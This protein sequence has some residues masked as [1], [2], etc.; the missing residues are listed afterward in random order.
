[1]DFETIFET[2]NLIFRKITEDDFFNLSPILKNPEI[3][4]AWEHGFSDKEVYN[5]IEENIRRYMEDKISYCIG[6]EKKTG[7][8]IGMIG[9]LM[10][11]I[12][13]EKFVG[14]GWI[15]DKNFWG[16]GYAVEGGRGAINYAF[17][18]MNND[19]VVATIRTENISSRKVAEKLGM[20]IEGSYIKKYKD[21]NMEHLIY[22]IYK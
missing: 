5:W 21:K 1:M 15:L 13:G 11:N 4:Y 16:K 10:E 9:P 8:I 6:I 22:K 20:K 3:M 18:N 2:E 17:E 12:E 19:C 14:V 7:K